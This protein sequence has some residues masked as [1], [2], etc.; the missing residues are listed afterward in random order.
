MAKKIKIPLEMVNGVTVRT[1]EELKENWDLEKIVSY[2]HNGRLLTWLNDRY[3]SEQAEKLKL[4]ETITNA[5]ELQKQLC[6]IFDMPFVEDECVDVHAVAV[7]IEKIERLRKLT[8]DDEILKNV[9]KV[10]FDQ[11]ELAHLLDE[12]EPII[13]LADNMFTI[14]LAVKNKK[15]IGVGTVTAVIVSNKPVDFEKMNIFFENIQFDE[16]YNNL[17]NTP[18]R[19][20]SRGKVCYDQKNFEKAFKLFK[21]AAEKG[22]A[23]ALDSLGRMY[24]HGEGVT[25]DYAE[26]VKWYC[27]AANQGYAVA[28]NHVGI[29]YHNGNGVTQDYVEAMKWFRKAADQGYPN[30]EYNIG[31][32]YMEGK[33]I[34]QDY[35]EAMKWYRKAADQGFANAQYA[36]GLM[37][38]KGMGVTQDYV[39]AIKWYRKAAD[40]GFATAYKNL[41]VI[42]EDGNGVERDLTIAKDYYVKAANAGNSSAKERLDKLNN[43]NKSLLDSI[44]DAFFD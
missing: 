40:Q 15:Y 29:M 18:E 4:L 1:V 7:K 28:K 32:M 34:T 16:K 17:V 39:E 23:I 26:A 10:A 9:D 20:L 30:A 25:Q 13:Y 5:H 35:A 24:E 33:G 6:S 2:Y 12:N 11:E 19:L 27:K 22:N 21:E 37:Y 14:P 43:N 3:Y 36:I 41:G 42:F 31:I 38:D 44:M 8:S